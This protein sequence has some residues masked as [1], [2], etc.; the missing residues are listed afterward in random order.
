MGVS[1]MLLGP[2]IDQL[3]RVTGSS[4]SAIGILFTAASI[5][6]LVGVVCSGQLIAHRSGHL[7]LRIGLLVMASGVSLLPF[8]TSI[9]VMFACEVAIGLGIGLIEIPCNSLVMWGEGGG[10]AINRLHAMWAVGAVVA[11]LIVGR[12]LAWTNGLHAGYFVAAAVAA[13]PFLLLTGRTEPPNPHLEHGRGIPSGARLLT[14]IGALWFFAYVGVEATFA[15]WIYKY[16]QERG[17]ASATT[18]TYLGAAFLL[19]FAVGRLAGI[20]I[21]RRLSPLQ[22]LVIDHLVAAAACALLLFASHSAVAIWIA[23]ITFGLGVAS[24]FP[25]MLALSEETV[26]S[27]GTVTSVYLVGS[28]LGTFVLP[29]TMGAL[30]ERY[31]ATALP[32]ECA[33]G[34]VITLLLLLAFVRI[35]HQTR[36][37]Y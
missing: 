3:R 28:S 27:T 17:I 20:T 13:A 26:P 9:I 15:G 19:A 2:S 11:P 33:I 22:V 16:A 21:A 35:S 23:T 31:G 8:A 29:A 24:M 34:A 30:I 4:V 37:N 10:A 18:A 14:A 36:R 1:A 6:Y 12:S 5:G 32:I 25:M 7:V